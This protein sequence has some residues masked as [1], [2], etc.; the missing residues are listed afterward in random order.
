ML[1]CEIITTKLLSGLASLLRVYCTWHVFIFF[2]VN[3]SFQYYEWTLCI[4]VQNEYTELII[5]WVMGF[6]KQNILHCEVMVTLLVHAS[7]TLDIDI[8]VWK[9]RLC[10]SFSEC[11]L[12]S[13][14]F[15]FEK[16]FMK[17][18]CT[19][20]IEILNSISSSF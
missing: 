8:W 18:N 17:P 6:T 1:L 19:K 7:A 4:S 14:R 20:L 16:C 2:I 3:I 12:F 5:K 11:C 9:F 10:F 15:R 13:H